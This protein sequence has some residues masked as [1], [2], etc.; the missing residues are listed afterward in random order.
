MKDG[1]NRFE[2]NVTAEDGT[3]KTYSVELY[4][5][6]DNHYL[7]SLEVVGYSLSFQR[8]VTQYELSVPTSIQELEIKAVADGT[9]ATI[10]GAG[11]VTLKK[12]R[13]TIPVT[14]TAS[15]G[16]QLT[17]QISVERQDVGVLAFLLGL[18]LVIGMIGSFGYCFYI[19]I[20]HYKK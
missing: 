11:K 7:K 9:D 14:V 12:D 6:N 1:S 19:L 18:F 8:D 16:S 15:D 20:L 17:Y 13:T 3:S 2:L 5:T 4:K 10:V